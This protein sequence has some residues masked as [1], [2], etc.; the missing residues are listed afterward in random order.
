MEET[1]GGNKS[2]P[3]VF[4][5]ENSFLLKSGG[6]GN[7]VHIGGKGCE[8]GANM[9]VCLGSQTLVAGKQQTHSIYSIHRCKYASQNGTGPSENEGWKP[10]NRD[11]YCL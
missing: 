2:N 3:L 1:H 5:A 8:M 4:F 10:K 6:E 7:N 9:S 11:G